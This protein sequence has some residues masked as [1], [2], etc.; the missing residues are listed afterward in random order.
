MNRIIH[1]RALQLADREKYRALRLDCLQKY[2][3]YFGSL[4]ENEK[5]SNTLK[6]DHI[7]AEQ[8]GKDFLLGAFA[9]EELVGMCGNIQENRVKTKHIAE[10]SH[11]YVNPAFS[12]QGIA[13]QLL[14]KTIAQVFS[15]AEVEQI[16]LG[17]VQSNKHALRLYQKLGFVQYGL[18]KNYYKVNTAYEALVL[19]QLMRDLFVKK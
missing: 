8:N 19:M 2:P 1:Y 5:E 6:F 18:H 13:T 10:I 9:D 4:Y 17:V 11:M 7:I 3:Q 12:Q 14:Q 15:N 16:I